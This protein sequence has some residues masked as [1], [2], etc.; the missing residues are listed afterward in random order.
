MMGYTREDDT[1]LSEDEDIQNLDQGISGKDD[2]SR[3]SDNVE[4][5]WS[6][7]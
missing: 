1:K 6:S 5:D 2:G 4:L 3:S 7:E